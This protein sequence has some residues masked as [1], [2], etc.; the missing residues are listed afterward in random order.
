MAAP[1]TVI[2]AWDTEFHENLPKLFP[3]A[4]MAP[5]LSGTKP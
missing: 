3:Q 2:V 4:D 1:V 5:T